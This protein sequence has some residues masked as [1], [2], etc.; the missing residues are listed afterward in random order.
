MGTL[1]V[2]TVTNVAGSGAP[3][4]AA[5]T[6]DNVAL[7]SLPQMEY[8]ASGTEPTSPSVGSLWYNTASDVFYMYDGTEWNTITITVPD[9]GFYGA[10][11]VFNGGRDQGTRSNAIQYITIASTGNTT[12]FGDLT[13]AVGDTSSFQGGGRGV[14]GGGSTGTDNNTGTRTNVI[15]YITVANTGN[16]T[17]FGD[18]ISAKTQL[19]GASNTSRG[20]FAGGTDS[21]G[22]TDTIEYITIASTGNGTD[23]GDLLAAQQL[24]GGGCA[25]SGIRMLVG[26]NASNT[27]QYVTIDTPGNAVDFGDLTSSR[28][29]V[30]ASGTAN[31]T[32]FG[33]GSG[34]VNTID[35]VSPAT[36]GNATDF[37]DL[38]V[39]RYSG[40]SVT[41]GTRSVFFGGYA[42]GASN[43]IDYVTL[44][45]AGNATDFGNLVAAA[46]NISGCSGD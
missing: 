13:V 2:D 6:V 42:S 8:A 45:N 39:A 40:D 4:A 23:F 25:S 21:S 34:P 16:A 17:D 36:T 27:I 24:V 26:T 3:D 19:G 28:Y 41:N 33:G 9:A 30:M 1:K 5:V 46:A 11:G 12:D 20:L 7:S 15:Q 35:Y 18:L 10:R 22:H 44:A 14:F 38:T 43:V 31:R 32:L 29:M 37:G